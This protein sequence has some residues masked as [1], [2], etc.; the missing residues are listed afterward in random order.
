MGENLITGKTV[1][2]KTAI[3]HQKSRRQCFRVSGEEGLGEVLQKKSLMRRDT[4]YV[5]LLACEDTTRDTG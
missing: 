4:V 2:L 3:C 1:L 5:Q